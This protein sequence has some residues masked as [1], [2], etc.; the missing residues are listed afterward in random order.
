KVPALVSF[1]F[2]KLPERFK[3]FLF[4]AFRNKLRYFISILCIV[5]TMFLIFT[6]VSFYTAK[7]YLTAHLFEERLNYDA[8][9]FFEN[10]VDAETMQQIR[11]SADVKHLKK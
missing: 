9:V 6:S 2:K 8:Q 3:L 1:I 7:N 10:V 11:S 4:A 5:L